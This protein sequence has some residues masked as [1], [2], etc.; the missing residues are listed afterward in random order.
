[1][2]LKEIM[3]IASDDN[4]MRLLRRIQG[5]IRNEENKGLYEVMESE[6]ENRKMAKEIRNSIEWRIWK[7][8]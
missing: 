6:K 8:F 3:A 5:N 1:M 4:A 7:C 2:T